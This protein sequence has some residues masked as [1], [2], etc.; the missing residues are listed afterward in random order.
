MNENQKYQ[1]ILQGIASNNISETCKTYGISRTI[2]YRWYRAYK[3][4]GMDGLA[5]KE[6]KPVMPNKV[7]R[8][9]EK[10]I[11]E[12]I[13]KHPEDGPK[14]I[15]YELEEEGIDVSD[16]GIY[17]VLK[18]KELNRR[19]QREAYAKQ[20]REKKRQVKG[21]LEISKDKHIQKPVDFKMKNPEHAHP[22]Y[23]CLQGI[24]YM[25]HF[26]NIGKVYQYVIYDVYSG[27][28]IVKLYQRKKAIHVM[29]FM[30]VKIIPL[31]RTFHFSIE[32][33]VTSKNL[34]FCTN[35]TR[36]K[37]IY[38]DFL[39]KNN[40]Q[41]ISLLLEDQE[42]FHPLHTF[43]SLLASDFYEHVLRDRSVES[44]E[45]LEIQINEYV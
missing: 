10:Y 45:Q 32:N 25:G 38:T 4:N 41:H 16:S 21:S 33:L 36:G 18:R 8:K 5:S 11:L 40:I 7:D 20:Q 9:T 15:H 14:R 22:G 3:Q 44:F 26:P 39:Q 30:Q 42:I 29:E 35:W 34:E 13:V 24:F 1:I 19:E 12:Y 27:L 37:H 43:C 17:N 23:L 2:Y 6:R 31:M 28:A